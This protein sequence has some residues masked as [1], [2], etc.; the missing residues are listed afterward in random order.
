MSIC[1]GIAGSRGRNPIGIFIHNDAGSKN[2]NAAFYRNWLPTHDLGNGFAH[3]YVANDGTLQAEDD[4]YM[5]WHCG[6]WDGNANYLSIEVCQSM[7]D[8]NVFKSNE[9]KALQLAA[10]K[11]KQYGITP[12]TSTI[13]LHQEVY[14]TACP[15]RSVEIHGGASA[16][17]AYFIAKIKQ[18]MG[19]NVSIP[20]TSSATN[21]STASVGG[22]A[23][24][25]FTYAVQLT[26][27]T[28]LPEV[29]NLE[30][31]AG[32]IGKRIANVAIKVNKGKI[33]YQVHV[34]GGGWLPYVTG[35]NWKDYDNGYAGNGQ[36]IDA[37][38]VYYETPADIVSK[39]GYQKAQYRTSPV[40]SGYYDWQFDDETCNDQDGYAG[41]FGVAIDRFQLF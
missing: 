19:Q 27:G 25:V 9:E 31:F 3:Y 12:S 41:C 7:G 20:V 34:L 33:K 35:Y 37:I 32:I 6:Q 23:G 13:R 11:C 15:H 10:Q 18:Y 4:T 28:I 8:L 30:D 36:A 40:N 2:A 39:Y 1:R 26:D 24:V 22:D 5:A 17:K 14:A 29:N 21:T 38:R 16:T